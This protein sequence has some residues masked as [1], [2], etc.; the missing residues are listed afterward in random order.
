MNSKDIW[1]DCFG[2]DFPS[3]SMV[4]HISNSSKEI[5]KNSV[6]FAMQGTKSHGCQYIHEAF[7]NG[8]AFVVTDEM[9]E[10]IDS[11][12]IFFVP[13]LEKKILNFLVQYYSIDITKIKFFGITG[14]NGKTSVAYLCYQLYKKTGNPSAYMGTLGFISDEYQSTPKETTPDIFSLFKHLASLNKIEGLGLF[15]ELSSHGLHQ[16]RLNMLD[17]EKVCIANI[18]SDHLDY[19]QTQE[20]YE[21]SKL[22]ILDLSQRSI[23]LVNYDV[24][25]VIKKHKIKDY[26]MQTFSDMQEKSDFL[27][28]ILP[29]EIDGYD[30]EISELEK[31][32]SIKFNTNLFPKFNIT[33]L[34]TAIVMLKNN[35]IKL[36]INK[37]VQNIALPKG[38]NTVFKST[39]KHVIIDFAHNDA[40]MNNILASYKEKYKDIWV[41]FGCG[42]ERDRPKRSRMY[43]TAQIY[44]SKIFFTSDNSRNE[45]F[46]SIKK[47]ALPSDLPDSTSIIEDR[48][49]AIE[50]A[51]LSLPKD[52]PLLILGR[53]HEEFLDIK[54]KT[55]AHSDI[56]SVKRFF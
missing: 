21:R 5:K 37:E 41:L 35:L 42:G 40:A 38:R 26:E 31:S 56:S 24:L 36:N 50:S 18:G 14:T 2:F 8:A 9:P 44:A 49:E 16:E 43:K 23:P 52:I 11:E 51:V 12:N 30:V 13:N 28:R 17:Y 19:H 48:E 6:F 1:K 7:T 34:C 25:E 20:D 27:F 15:L 54:N 47:D 3:S 22:S 10:N 39:S 29:G 55:I 45:D 53:G 4:P 32:K 46:V 33:N